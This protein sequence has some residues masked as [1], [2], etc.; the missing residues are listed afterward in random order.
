MISVLYIFFLFSFTLST[1]FTIMNSFVFV[2]FLL[3]QIVQKEI[4]YFFFNNWE[5]EK[6]KMNFNFETSLRFIHK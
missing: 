2:I 5:N 6:L 4:Y 3:I 1:L